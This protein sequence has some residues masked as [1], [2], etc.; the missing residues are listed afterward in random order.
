MSCNRKLSGEIVLL[1]TRHLC[2]FSRPEGQNLETEL[3]LTQGNECPHNLEKGLRDVE[4]LSCFLLRS[5]HV[6]Y[7]GHGAKN[8]TPPANHEQDG[9]ACEKSSYGMIVIMQKLFSMGLRKQ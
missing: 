2:F 4:Y 1:G 5:I 3:N 7:L 8:H 9:G 6:R